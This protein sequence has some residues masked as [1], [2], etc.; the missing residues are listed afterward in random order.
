V[1]TA[2]AGGA[3]LL[4][5][6]AAVA[7]DVP[8]H[9]VLVG[10]PAR[11]AEVS[12]GDQGPR[13]ER[14]Y[15]EV[16]A[17]VAADD[18]CTVLEPTLDADEAGFLAANQLLLDHAAALEPDQVLAVAVRPEGGQQPPSVTDKFVQR[19]RAAGLFVLEIDPRP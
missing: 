9:L 12:V 1:V 13:W 2:A 7:Q 18:R 16:L 3:D 19:A 11:F 8:L 6:E 14:A 4:L 5:A 15:G 17:H 10:G